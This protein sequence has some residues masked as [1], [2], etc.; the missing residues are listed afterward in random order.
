MD[1]KKLDFWDFERIKNPLS[2]PLKRA[3]P[4]DREVSKKEMHFYL[5]KL[6][7]RIQMY[8]DDNCFHLLNG[9]FLLTKKVYDEKYE[10]EMLESYL[11]AQD[12]LKLFTYCWEINKNES[13][14]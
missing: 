2:T 14:K 11:K 5:D 13:K 12:M 1:D 8:K 6:N 3:F 4:V 7:E 10:N 9:Y